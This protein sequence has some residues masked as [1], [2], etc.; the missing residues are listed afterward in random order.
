M[1][2]II[3]F[4]II[5]GIKVAICKLS[6]GKEV[7]NDGYIVVSLEIMVS[8]DESSHWIAPLASPY[9]NQNIYITSLYTMLPKCVVFSF[10]RQCLS[11]GFETYASELSIYRIPDARRKN[12]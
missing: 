1:V 10:I 4:K 5:C 8:I 11:K 2:I 12:K 3:D 6:K 9:Q 7:V